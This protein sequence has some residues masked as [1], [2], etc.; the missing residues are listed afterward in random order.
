VTAA[1]R[2]GRRPAGE[3]TRTALLDAARAVFAE[4]GYEGATVRAIAARAGVDAAMVNHWF[5]GKQGLF[6]AA[7]EL[8]ID[9]GEV[10]ATVLEGGPDTVGE[11]L[12]RTFVTVWDRTGGGPFAALV[13]SVSSHE[14]AARMLR[15]F[16]TGVLFGPV[17]ARLGVES[18]A[19]R[20]ALCGSQIVG[21]GMMRYVVRLEPLASADV[22]TVVAAIAPNLQRYL[23]GDL[24]LPP[25]RDG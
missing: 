20:A 10:V 23:T 7:M 22:E 21:L 5:G 8:P 25:D 14:L 24:A 4:Q 11:R 13:R 17:A 15:E 12:V 16:V 19:L 2:R 1:R 6:A 9:P 18:P 3:D